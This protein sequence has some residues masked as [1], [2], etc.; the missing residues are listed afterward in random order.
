MQ[1]KDT[2]R[3]NKRSQEILKSYYAEDVNKAIADMFTQVTHQNI[4]I[5]K[6]KFVADSLQIAQKNSPNLH[7]EVFWKQ[8]E[9]CVTKS[10]Q[11][12]TKPL[13]PSNGFQ[14]ASKLV[15][16]PVKDYSGGKIGHDEQ[17]A[18]PRGKGGKEIR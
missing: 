13:H 8:M 11:L 2:V 12:V 7:G 14:P 4:E 1:V 10:L 5:E 16:T 15:V 17:L 9:A 3:L 6:L 18:E